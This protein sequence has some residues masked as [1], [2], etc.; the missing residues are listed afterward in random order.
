MARTKQS[1]RR[2]TGYVHLPA[3]EDREAAVYG[4]DD[5]VPSEDAERITNPSAWQSE[6]EAEDDDEDGNA[7]IRASS[8]P[9]REL[10]RQAKDLGVTFGSGGIPK[11]ASD[12]VIAAAIRQRQG[13]QTGGQ[14]EGTI[15]PTD[16]DLGDGTAPAAPEDNNAPSGDGNGAGS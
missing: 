8:V 9:R 5:D 11:N 10:V 4:P 6:D 13:R 1:T 15:E 16:L 3:T 2:L 12:A 7:A 14:P